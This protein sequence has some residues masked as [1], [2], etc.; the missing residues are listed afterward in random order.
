MEV[1]IETKRDLTNHS[2]NVTAIGRNHMNT[3][4][5]LIVYHQI[6]YDL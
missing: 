2:G 6:F 5:M 3:V 1:G 4:T